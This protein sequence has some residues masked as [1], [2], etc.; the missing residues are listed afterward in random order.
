MFVNKAK[1]IITDIKPDNGVCHA[2]D[3]VLMPTA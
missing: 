3:L 1:I 2:I